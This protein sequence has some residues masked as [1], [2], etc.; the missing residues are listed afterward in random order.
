MPHNEQNGA[1]AR[2][3]WRTGL[4]A[5]IAVAAA[6]WFLRQTMAISMPLV[7][8]LL[9]ALAVW[10]MVAAISGAMPRG[11]RWLGPTA[12]LLLVVALLV[13]FL[14]AL[15]LAA[16]QAYTIVDNVGPRLQ[17]WLSS[18]GL[19]FSLPS[20]EGEVAAL[21]GGQGSGAGLS[22]AME[23]LGLT[24]STLGGIVLILFLMLLMLTEAENWHHKFTAISANG[25]DRSLRAMGR[26]IGSKFRTY[27]T[28]RLILG[29]I[30]AGLYVAWL[31]AWSVDYLL[32]W[33]LLAVLLNFVPTVG[34]IIAGMLP[35]A[36]ALVVKEPSTAAIVAAGLLVIE[37]FMGN[38]V[39]PKL[40]GRRIALSPLVVLVALGFWTALW[41][42]PGALLSVPLTVIIITT[43]AHFD[44]LKPAALLLTDRTSIDDLGDYTGAS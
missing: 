32:L 31:F 7:A 44:A 43:L 22:T 29:A 41:G 3:D 17:E 21:A 13:A 8:A 42:I 34:S 24:L 37:Q 33:G 12:G 9:L 18:L 39:D 36:Y 26:S 1:G 4:I 35:V 23:A 27:F 5:V 40:M 38:F 15:G 16:R 28:T 14:A 2:R 19:P 10:P 30:T 25:S 11:L 20:S 6:Y